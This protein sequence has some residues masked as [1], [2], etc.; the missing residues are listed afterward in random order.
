MLPFRPIYA[1]R[2]LIYSF[3]DGY[4]GGKVIY[5]LKIC[6]LFRFDRD[7]WFNEKCVRECV[8]SFDFIFIR[9]GGEKVRSKRYLFWLNILSNSF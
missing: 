4:Y 9:E 3:G 5:F 7:F 6:P 8:E 2:E 1:I